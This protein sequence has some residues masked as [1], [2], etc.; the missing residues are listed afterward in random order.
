MVCT[1]GGMAPRPLEVGG[2]VRQ[3]IDAHHVR[4][5]ERPG[6]RPADGA[7][8]Q[9]VHLFDGQVL[10]LHEAHR[11]QHDEDADPVGDEVGRV[12]REH[13]FL[14]QQHVG[15]VR[16]GGN[17]RRVRL[18]RG[19]DLHQPHVARRIEKVRAKPAPA[20]RLGSLAAIDATGRPLVLVVRIASPLQVRH[21]LVQQ[22]LL[23]GEVL[24]DRL[25]H[26]VA[27]GQQRQVVI[28]VA[29]A[30]ARRVSGVVE[31]RRL[32]SS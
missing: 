28:E 22:G 30:D 9:R 13:H 27:I 19:N 7:A 1:N 29:H 14:A 24:G 8:G 23:D 3:H 4:Q 20:D 12:A 25:D 6:A 26:P 17:G 15:E 18:R 11:F 31:R 32:A 2:H 5:P 16:D 21:D 10:L